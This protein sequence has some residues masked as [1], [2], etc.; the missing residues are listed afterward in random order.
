MSVAAI[1]T[2][3]IILNDLGHEFCAILIDESHA[4]SIKEESE[5]L[6]S[7]LFFDVW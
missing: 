4:V 7:E 2:T 3:N 5:F 6:D 1:E